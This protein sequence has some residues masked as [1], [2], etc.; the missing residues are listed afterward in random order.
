MIMYL[1]DDVSE[2][3]YELLEGF[4]IQVEDDRPDG[5]SINLRPYSRLVQTDKYRVEEVNKPHFRF[6]WMSFNIYFKDTGL[7]L[8]LE[9]DK[10]GDRLTLVE[11][12]G[13][14]CNAEALDDKL[15]KLNLRNTCI[16]YQAVQ[17]R[18]QERKNEESLRK[19]LGLI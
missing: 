2:K 17:E 12:N 4:N 18:D 6:K 19:M 5:V 7:K 9:N 1:K 14:P 3:I 15:R 11:V 10:N 13:N 16:A 8:T